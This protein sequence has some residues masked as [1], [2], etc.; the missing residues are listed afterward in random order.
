VWGGGVGHA[1]ERV[2]WGGAGACTYIWTTDVP[3]A[4]HMGRVPSGGLP[5][6]GK[7]SQLQGSVRDEVQLVQLTPFVA[8]H[9]RQFCR[10]TH[11]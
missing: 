4:L 3:C 9:L 8:L 7:G 1:G 11:A 5:T 10:G 2:Q 6:D